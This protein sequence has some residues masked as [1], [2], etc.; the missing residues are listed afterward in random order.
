VSGIKEFKVR[1][2]EMI[3]G[4]KERVNGLEKGERA[5]KVQV[6]TRHDEDI[7]MHQFLYLFSVQVCLCIPSRC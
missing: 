5:G 3:R 7:T 6:T 4:E 2:V 1:D